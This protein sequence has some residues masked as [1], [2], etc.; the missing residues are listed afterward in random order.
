MPVRLRPGTQRLSR[1]LQSR[2]EGQVRE[3][4]ERLEQDAAV[5]QRRATSQR[6][7]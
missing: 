3:Q 7:R 6:L 2:P 1:V 5:V 4:T